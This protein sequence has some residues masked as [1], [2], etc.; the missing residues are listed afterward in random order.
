MDE[1]V[2]HDDLASRQATQRLRHLPQDLFWAH[3]NTN[4]HPKDTMMPKFGDVTLRGEHCRCA[5]IP[6]R[7]HWISQGLNI[8]WSLT[9]LVRHLP[10]STASGEAS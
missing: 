3:V 4:R 8:L 2:I 1:D 5:R 10:D 7:S 6:A 9:A